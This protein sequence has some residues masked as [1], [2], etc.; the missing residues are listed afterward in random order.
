[1]KKECIECGFFKKKKKILYS[2]PNKMFR[3]SAPI[4][5]CSTVFR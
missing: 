2:Y 5:T 3:K 1:M 4:V